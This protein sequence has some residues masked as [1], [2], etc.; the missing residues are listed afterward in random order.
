MRSLTLFIIIFLYAVINSYSQEEVLVWSDEFSGSYAPDASNWGYDTGAGGWGNREVQ[1]Y[2]TQIQNARQEGG[3]LIIEAV[4]T[5]NTWTSARLL[6]N[7]KHEFKY[8]RFVWRARLPV[9]S[10]TWPALWLLGENFG[11]AGWPGCGEIDVMEHVGKDPGWVQSA[12]HTPSSYGNTVNF[13]KKFIATANSEFHVYQ[14]NWTYEKLEFSVD[15]VLMYTYKPA[16]RNTSTWPFDKPF[17]LIMNVAMGGN[18]GSDPQYETGGL[19]NGIDPTLTSARMEIDYVRVYQYP[20]GINE[21]LPVD[22][23]SKEVKPFIF[24]NPSSGKVNI[25][26]PAGSPATGYLYDCLGQQVLQMELT[27]PVNEVDLTSVGKGVYCIV[28]QT[29]EKKYTSKLIVQ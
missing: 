7:N 4:K 24:P 2:T 17:F 25:T 13:K 21:N 10:G 19:K 16:V 3:L 11:S 18:M 15:S 14:L 23:G 28:L 26:L 9:G 27:K 1:T 8:G 5:G 6:T 20:N 12:V 29:D 22:K